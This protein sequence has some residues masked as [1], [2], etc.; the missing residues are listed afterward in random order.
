MGKKKQMHALEPEIKTH[1][2]C[3]EAF[4][5]EDILGIYMYITLT[6]QAEP[7]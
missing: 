3:S 5:I 6:G 7:F 2:F 4:C 1:T